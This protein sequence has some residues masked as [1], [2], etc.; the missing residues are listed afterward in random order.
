MNKIDLVIALL[1]VWGAY[2]GYRNGFLLGLLSL[3]AIVLGIFGGF[4]LMGEGML[5]LQREFNADKSVLPYLSFLGVFLTIVIGVTLL[6]RMLKALLDKTFLGKVDQMMGAL[7]GVFKWLFMMSVLLW[8]LDSLHY[9]PQRDW[10]EGSRLYAFTE[11]V[12]GQLA[13]W[14][15]GFLPF[16]KEVFRQY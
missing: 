10:T 16:F 3:L 6:G 2:Q 9:A 8:I 12:A 7:L 13:I 5:W 4:K 1:L 11:D 15:S 14:M